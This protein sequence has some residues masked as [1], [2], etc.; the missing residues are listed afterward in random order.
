MHQITS[1]MWDTES[2][3]MSNPV[4]MSTIIFYTGYWVSRCKIPRYYSWDLLPCEWDFNRLQIK[5]KPF[6]LRNN[7]TEQNPAQKASKHFS[8][9]QNYIVDSLQTV[10][11]SLKRFQISVGNF[12][13]FTE[14]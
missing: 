6:W 3:F 5:M 14:L 9:S 10:Q 11:D 7:Y 4:K 1:E 13:L 8:F 2:H 12:K